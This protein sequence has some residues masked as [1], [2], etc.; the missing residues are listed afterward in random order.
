MEGL[1]PVP[2]LPLPHLSVR[3]NTTTQLRKAPT[4][5]QCEHIL[6][7]D[8]RLLNLLPLPYLRAP[9]S[10]TLAPNIHSSTP[11]PYPPRLP[12]LTCAHLA[13]SHPTAS[14]TPLPRQPSLQRHH[15]YIPRRPDHFRNHGRGSQR[16]L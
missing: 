5:P 15:A 8:S 16:S 11:N 14:S 3:S 13:V 12:P 10:K 6:L 4:V 2:H 1:L 7:L 9:R